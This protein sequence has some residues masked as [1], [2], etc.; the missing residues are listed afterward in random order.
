MQFLAPPWV[1]YTGRWRAKC[2]IG[3][4]HSK[5]VIGQ[6]KTNFRRFACARSSLPVPALGRAVGALAPPPAPR[7]ETALH[8][9]GQ[10]GLMCLL[11]KGQNFTG[12]QLM[13]PVHGG[14][15]EKPEKTKTNWRQP[16]HEGFG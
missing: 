9:V 2:N 12:L 7:A 11:F 5:A 1:C 13:V 6:T 8:C 3:A 10:Y 15:R 16:G 4:I 14:P